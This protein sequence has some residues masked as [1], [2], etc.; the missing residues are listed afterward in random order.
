MKSDLP[1]PAL[2]LASLP[3]VVVATILIVSLVFL[4]KGSQDIRSSA[5]PPIATSPTPVPVI[6]SKPT[7]NTP[8][9]PETRCSSPY[10]P[11]CGVNGQTYLN[12]CEANKADVQIATRKECATIPITATPPHSP[13][14]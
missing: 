6:T 9:I 10:S 7:S 12:Q 14:L 11:V 2:V 13:S 1:V 4:P 3:I 8:I 5:A